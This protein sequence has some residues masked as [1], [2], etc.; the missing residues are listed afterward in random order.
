M[1]L[2]CIEP[3]VKVNNGKLITA[4]PIGTVWEVIEE[5]EEYI[6]KS[7]DEGREEIVPLDLLTE[8]F[9]EVK[10]SEKLKCIDDLAVSFSLNGTLTTIA[11]KGTLWEKIKECGEQSVLERLGTEFRIT[12]PKS[13][14]D[15]HFEE[16]VGLDLA[17]KELETLLLYHVD[18]ETELPKQIKHAIKALKGEESCERNFRI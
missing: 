6:L 2:K 5:G 9:I 4:I 11:T 17:I 3:L 14:L 13:L 16:F 1:L 8:H 10:R 18:E 15:M 12:V 7:D